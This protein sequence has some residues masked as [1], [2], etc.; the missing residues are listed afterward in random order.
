MKK[1]TELNIYFTTGLALFAMFFGAGNIVFP[2]MLGATAGKHF[3]YAL[4][5]FLISGVGMPM[6]GLYTVGLYK[7]NYW[8][9]FNI[10][11]KIPAFIIV[12][13]LIFIIGPL[14]AAPRTEIVVYESLS[15][16]LPEFFHAH[17]FF[18]LL[19][20]TIVFILVFNKQRVLDVIGKGIS[21]IKLCTFFILIIASIIG[22]HA[23]FN[24]EE[25]S[26]LPVVNN[27]FAAGY[28]TMDLLGAFF[29]SH[30]AYASILFKCKQKNIVSEKEIA[31]IHLKSCIIGGLLL[32]I[33]YAGFAYCQ[34]SP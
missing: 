26:L 15:H 20:F 33:I 2:L 19:Y 30:V 34:T 17:F 1:I 5:A 4:I 21:P 28:S 12:T 10:L 7:G 9:F 11:G 14:F 8:E 6:M 25:Q 23:Y 16:F 29:Y 3:S 32:S 13:F 24:S 27:A 22:K 18:S 31:T